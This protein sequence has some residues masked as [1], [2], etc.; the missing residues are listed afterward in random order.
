MQELPL[1]AIFLYDTTYRWT[2]SGGSQCQSKVIYYG[3][4]LSHAS[5]EKGKYTHASTITGII[6]RG[7]QP[8]AYKVMKAFPDTF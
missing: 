5:I 8:P 3:Q 2:G 1:G 4:A 6:E 7:D